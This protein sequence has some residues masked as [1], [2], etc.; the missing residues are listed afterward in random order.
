MWVQTGKE[1]APQAPLPCPPRGRRAPN[2][3][4]SRL[5]TSRTL[6]RTRGAPPLPAA[7]PRGKKKR[8]LCQLP[9]A[10]GCWCGVPPPTEP[11]ARALA[12]AG[13]RERPSGWGLGSGCRRR[14]SGGRGGA[15]R[16]GR[17]RT[18]GQ[19]LARH[20]RGE[21]C[22]A[23]RGACGPCA[24]PAQHRGGTAHTLKRLRRGEGAR[25]GARGSAQRAAQSQG[26]PRL[27][28]R[29]ALASAPQQAPGLG[30]QR[31]AVGERGVFWQMAARLRAAW[32]AARGEG[33]ACGEG[34]RKLPA[35][36]AAR[37]NAALAGA[38][39]RAAAQRRGL[40]APKPTLARR[41]AARAPK[42]AALPQ[43][44]PRR[45]LLPSDAPR[46]LASSFPPRSNAAVQQRGRPGRSF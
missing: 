23:R 34:K 1:E 35:P 41:D 44:S 5:R 36:A 3:L 21:V 12:A 28:S 9:R 30:G 15:G 22:G 16:R 38:L 25:G 6:R 32:R 27:G 14:A 2:R 37:R 20:A 33:V 13:W 4:H 45:S 18:A 39:M 42:T 10:R 19:R 46:V 40:G 7:T 17:A 26:T 8:Q 11:P 29:H 43:R 31:L 24:P